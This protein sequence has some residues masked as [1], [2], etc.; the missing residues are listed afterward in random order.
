M[1]SPASRAR[2]KYLSHHDRMSAL[3]LLL[4]LTAIYS[5]QIRGLEDA[6]REI[7]I[8]CARR[9]RLSVIGPLLRRPLSKVGLR[10]CLRRH[11]SSSRP[12]HLREHAKF[13]AEL[14]RSRVRVVDDGDLLL[15]ACVVPVR[16]A[17]TS[18]QPR[19]VRAT[20]KTARVYRL[21]HCFLRSRSSVSTASY[22]SLAVWSARFTSPKT[23]DDTKVALRSHKQNL[24]FSEMLKEPRLPRR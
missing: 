19:Y 11:P 6:T 21:T 17:R 23:L 16:R 15:L 24:D 7:G 22:L 2:M 5:G 12:S 10:H 20:R 4:S 18:L 8:A 13:S 9:E 3:A 1:W 14:A